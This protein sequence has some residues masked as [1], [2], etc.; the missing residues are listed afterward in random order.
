MNQNYD[1]V[2]HFLDSY[3]K[4]SEIR[5]QM[6]FDAFLKR[7]KFFEFER[8]IKSLIL[9]ELIKKHDSLFAKHLI[10]SGVDVDFISVSG[11][12]A[13]SYACQNGNEDIV[14]AILKKSKKGLDRYSNE[15][16]I[17]LIISIYN[18]HPDVANLLIEEG[19]DLNK[20]DYFDN[21][22]VDF[23]C[24]LPRTY[25]LFMPMLEENLDKFNEENQI[26]IKKIRLKNIFN[27]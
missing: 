23:V 21:S 18:E 19:A 6:D 2:N 17:P 15:K 24:D 13:L 20:T 11:W 14:R 16:S 8:R 25:S 4:S 3:S 26:K 9:I 7:T 22:V 12:D 10:N 27:G 1:A 5:Y